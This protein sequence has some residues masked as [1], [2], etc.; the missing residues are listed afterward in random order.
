MNLEKSNDLIKFLD[1]SFLKGEIKISILDDLKEL[2]SKISNLLKF[3]ETDPVLNSLKKRRKELNK[4]L[5]K[6]YISL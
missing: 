4:K 1:P 5:K 6:E 3:R 2:E